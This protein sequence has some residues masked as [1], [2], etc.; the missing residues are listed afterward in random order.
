M[1]SVPRKQKEALV[2]SLDWQRRADQ[3]AQQLAAIVESSDDA[4]LSISLDGIITSWNGGAEHL[5]G[6]TAAEAIG[7]PILIIYQDGHKD[8]GA[9]VLARIRKGE[10]ID[11]YETIRQ[12]KNGSLL[13]ISLTVSPVRDLDGE[14]IG[15]SKI[16]RD[17]TD[18]RKAEDAILQHAREQ[19][20]LYKLTDALY[21]GA[22]MPEVFEASINAIN[23]ALHC[24]R[25]AIALFNG[26]GVSEFVAWRGL[27]DAYRAAAA[28]QSAWTHGD[29]DAN[30]VVLRDLDDVVGEFAE[31][32]QSARAEGMRGLALLPVAG[33]I[34]VEGTFMVCYAEPHAF[35][36][37][38][39]DIA[40]SIARQIGFGIERGRT[41][42]QRDLLVV[43]LG[44]RVKN[45]L[46]NVLAIAQQTFRKS[47]E[48]ER[49]SFEGRILALAQTHSRLAEANWSGVSLETMLRDELAP[50]RGDGGAS[51]TLAGPPVTLPPSIAVMLGVAFHELATN[52]SKHGALSTKAGKIDVSWVIRDDALVA[53]WVESGGPPVREPKHAGFGRMLLERA[54]PAALSCAVSLQFAPGGVN[55][56]IVTP[57]K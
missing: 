17:I 51:I 14:I 30:P 43:E 52:A 57:L 12:R 40:L 23:Q 11:H 15:A 35:T 54:V 18:R 49:L 37:H 10:R 16:A 25:A 28:G 4:I 21:H 29:L 44:H 32:A 53:R 1:T 33:S 31:I 13:D 8:D 36:R 50:Y 41:E 39:I 3:A 48:E 45:T 38:E 26:S 55:Y 19:T 56:E 20:A 24:D 46:A 5:F 34:G 47:D 9:M 22:P 42:R 2:D 6:Y 27:S 7:K